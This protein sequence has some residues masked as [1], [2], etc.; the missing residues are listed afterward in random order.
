VSTE[1]FLKERAVTIAVAEEY[2]LP[3][4]YDPKGKL[5]A[6]ACRTKRISPDR[7]MVDVPVV[8]RV[9][10]RL[11][12]YF[13]DF[14]KLDGRISDTR[15]GSF[16]LELDVSDATRERLANKLTWL[17]GKLK[18]PSIPELRREGARI[19]PEQSHATLTLADGA[20]H[21]CFIVDM[22]VGG[23]AVSAQLQPP[24]G[25]PLA[26]GAC[27][28]RVVR[29]FAT[30]FAVRFIE[31]QSRHNLDRLITRPISPHLAAAQRSRLRLPV[32]A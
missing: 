15:P 4:W 7:M 22:S 20:I 18:D 6:F 30:G 16:L 28:G 29:L 3:N 12:S 5:R 23:V 21:E 9:G 14:G 24:I 8:G 1:S 2:T 10:D 31:R 19:V 32:R 13:Q 17:E 27:V 11:T 25:T 26:V